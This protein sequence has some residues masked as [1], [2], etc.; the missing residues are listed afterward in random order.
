MIDVA[1]VYVDKDFRCWLIDFNPFG[2]LTDALLFSWSELECMSSSCIEFRTID[3]MIAMQPKDSL[4]YR[5]P[6]DLIDLSNRQGIDDFI[7]NIQKYDDE[8]SKI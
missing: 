2:M 4:V 8:S 1:D 5:L 3:S 6:K 7:A